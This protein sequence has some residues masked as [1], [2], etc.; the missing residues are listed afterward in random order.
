MP[1]RTVTVTTGVTELA[2]DNRRRRTLTVANAG[3][4]T[5]FFSQDPS[6]ILAAGFPLGVGQVVSLT[7]EDGDEPDLPLFAQVSAGTVDARVQESVGL[8]IPLPVH[9]TPP[10]P[11]G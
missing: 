7:R 3:A 8:P 2:G 1:W 5:F 9:E 11:G 10:P 6:N 4:A